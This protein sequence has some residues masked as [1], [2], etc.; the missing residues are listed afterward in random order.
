MAHHETHKMA[1][2]T[3][4]DRRATNQQPLAIVMYD[5]S[6]DDD[7]EYFKNFLK[8]SGFLFAQDS[9][10]FKHNHSKRELY[11]V[12][13]HVDDT[14]ARKYKGNKS[15]YIDVRIVEVAPGGVF[16]EIIRGDVKTM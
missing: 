4:E 8:R 16:D 10:Y 2:V 9:V 7:R 5:I 6:D 12:K 3:S 11:A 1:S 15:D 13:N 14:L